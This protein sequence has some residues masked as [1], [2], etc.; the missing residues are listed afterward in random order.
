MHKIKN[1]II[2]KII[3]GNFTR[4]SIDVLFYIARF[5]DKTGR[6]I[7]VYYAKVCEELDMSPQT[8]YDAIKLLAKEGIIHYF[9]RTDYDFDVLIIDNDFTDEN[10]SGGYLSL[11]KPIFYSKA[12]RELKAREKQLLLDLMINCLSNGGS[13]SAGRESFFQRYKE[14]LHV[15][16][17]AIQGYL[18]SMKQFF[19]I[20]WHWSKEDAGM[21]YHFTYKNPEE[22]NKSEKKILSDEMTW[23]EH[24]VEVEARR[25]RIKNVVQKQIK[26]TAELLRQYQAQAKAGGEVISMLLKGC[27]EESL[28]VINAYKPP[29]EKKEYALRPKLIHKLLRYRLGLE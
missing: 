24:F 4:A 9:K 28:A 3:C 10:Y 19:K 8:F 15:K 13:W 2:R 22:T 6:I 17:R 12:F 18:H 23:N 25:H 1:P 11:R 29:R 26:D 27:I 20:S 21:I 5:Q 7:G 16:D 14:I